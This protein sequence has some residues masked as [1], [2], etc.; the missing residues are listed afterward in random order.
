MV[1]PGDDQLGLEAVDQPEAREPHAVDRRAVGRVADGP[2]AE[3]DLLDPQRPAGGDRPRHRRAVAVGG[4]H[5]RARSPAMRRSARRSACSPSASI[6]SSL[7]SSTRMVLMLRT[8]PD[9]WRPP[10]TG[11]VSSSSRTRSPRSRRRRGRA[12][13]PARSARR[14]PAAVRRAA[15]RTPRAHAGRE[16]TSSIVPTSTRFMWR[17][18]V[19]ASIQNSSTSRVE[20]PPPAARRRGRTDVVGLGRRERGEVVGA[21]EHRRGLRAA[22]RDRPGTASAAPAR[23]RSAGRHGGPDPIAVGAEVAVAARVE[24]VRGDALRR[25][26]RRRAAAAR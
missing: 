2:V 8:C 18:K 19:S 9:R 11:T 22:P 1:D 15:A 16:R 3:V 21:G 23:A 10:P 17:M 5:R 13:G 6:P 20:R 7:V 26:P 24:A 25:A 4:D 14:R 12:H